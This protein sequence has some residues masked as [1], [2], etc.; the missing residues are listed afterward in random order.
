MLYFSLEVGGGNE[1][2]K[3]YG[4]AEGLQIQTPAG[5][6]SRNCHDKCPLALSDTQSKSLS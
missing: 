5:G 1:W 3:L 4:T 6:L 2:V